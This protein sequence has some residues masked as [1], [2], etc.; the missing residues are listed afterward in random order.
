MLGEG[1]ETVW[2]ELGVGPLLLEFLFCTIDHALHLL[3]LT[4]KLDELA[5]SH[6]LG[7]AVARRSMLEHVEDCGDVLMGTG[8]ELVCGADVASRDGL[9]VEARVTFGFDGVGRLADSFRLDGALFVV[10]H[11]C[12]SAEG[13]L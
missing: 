8:L 7:V 1:G 10:L 3:S 5:R 9:A 12:W 13:L 4:V 6:C 11:G 2:A